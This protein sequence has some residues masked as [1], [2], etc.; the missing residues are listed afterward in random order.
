MADIDLI[1]ERSMYIG[2]KFGIILW[3][4][5]LDIFFFLAYLKLAWRGTYKR[6]SQIFYAVHSMHSMQFISISM[7]VNVILTQLMWTERRD[8][9]PSAFSPENTTVWYNTLGT[10]VIVAAKGMGDAVLLDS[11]TQWLYRCYTTWGS[12]LWAI[13]FPALV[14]LGSVVMAV[15]MTI[16][17]AIPG[18]NFWQGFAVNFGI[19]WIASTVSF[20]IIITAMIIAHLFPMYFGLRRILSPDLVRTYTGVISILVESSLPV[21]I[22]GIAYLALYSRNSPSAIAVEFVWGSFAVLS[23]QLIILRGAMS[24]ACDED[25]LAHVTSWMGLSTCEGAP[26]SGTDSPEMKMSMVGE[27]SENGGETTVVAPLKPGVSDHSLEC[28]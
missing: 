3:R 27:R 18:A 5:S 7:G 12:K 19:A 14:Y 4:I 1:I 23:P 16:E 10:A 11:Q 26:L 20:N 21:I 17:G 24:G 25:M 8:N 22:L 2:D 13:A 6:K 9:D 15:A 28:A